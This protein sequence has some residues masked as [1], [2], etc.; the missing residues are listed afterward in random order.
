MVSAESIASRAADM[1]REE[2]QAYLDQLEP[3]ELENLLYDWSFW[4]RPNQLPPDG[5]KWRTWL[6]LAGRGF[7]KTRAG[8]EWVNKGVRT[9]LYGRFHIIGPTAS[10]TRDTMVEGPSGIIETSPP[11]FRPHYSPTKRRIDWPNGAIAITFSA[12]EPERLRGPQCFVADTMVST[13]FGPV[14]IQDVRP[15]DLVSTR[16]GSRIVTDAMV[17]ANAPIGRVRFG[18]GSELIGTADHPVLLSSAQWV[19]LSSLTPGT[20]VCDGGSAGEATS[21]LMVGARCSTSIESSGNTITA[22]SPKVTTSIIG[23]PTEPTT[24]LPTWSFSPLTPTPTGTS[25]L[26]RSSRSNAGTVEPRWSGRTSA[27]WSS[28]LSAS[29]AAPSRSERPPVGAIIAGPSSLPEG[30]TSVRS[31]ASTWVP[32]GRATVYNLTVADLPEFIANGLVVHNCSAAWADELCAWRYQKEA[33]MQ[34]MMGL[35]LGRDP[36]VIVTT[37]PKPQKVLK[38]LMAL[39]ST[40]TVKGTTYENLDNLAP[41]FAEQIITAY[42][43]TRDGRQELLAEILDDAPGALWHRQSIEDHRVDEHPPLERIVVSLDPSTTAGDEADET[44]IVVAGLG[45]DGH[46]YLLEDLSGR[47]KV[48][49]WSRKAVYTY[50]KHL[51]DRIVAEKNQG[52]DMVETTLRIVDPNISVRLVHASKAKI[53][54]AEPVAAAAERGMIHHVG[55]FPVLEDQLCEWEAGNPNSPDRLDAFVWAFTDLLIGYRARTTGMLIPD[56]DLYSPSYWRGI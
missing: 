36:R 35:R 1:T 54:R 34:L 27:S 12:D 10:D 31:V 37:T 30:V 5:D 3:E 46:G 9:G 49:E 28:A 40:V 25:K 38:D 47:Y 48:E 22:R 29:I 14:P 24:F 8:A 7:G 32:A 26:V 52:G 18:D 42:E 43:G 33:W 55:T 53:T 51:A 20:L 6:L 56:T 44:G 11:D 16:L 15:G 4:A 50:W 19:P 2:L 23:M 13:P 21:S 17:T 45:V 39:S 41:A